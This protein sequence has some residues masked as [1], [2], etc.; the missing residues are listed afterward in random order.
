MKVQDSR[1]TTTVSR[2]INGGERSNAHRSAVT[3]ESRAETCE[4]L[5][6]ILIRIRRC[7][8]I[9]FYIRTPSETTYERFTGPI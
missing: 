1:G 4:A 9:E 8:H 3:E 6:C 2:V 5:S 7:V